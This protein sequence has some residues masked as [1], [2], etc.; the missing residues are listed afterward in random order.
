MGSFQKRQSGSFRVRQGRGQR[1]VVGPGASGGNAEAVA[2]RGDAQ[3]AAAAAASSATAAQNAAN[4]VGAPADSAVTA[5]FGGASSARAATDARYSRKDAANTYSAQQ[6]V[7][8]LRL[9]TDPEAIIV[10]ETAGTHGRRLLVTVVDPNSDRAAQLELRPGTAVSQ[11]TGASAAQQ[12]QILLF[13]RVG[14]DYERLLIDGYGKSFRV[15]TSKRGAGTQRPI[16]FGVEDNGVSLSVAA[17]VRPDASFRVHSKLTLGDTGDAS[18]TRAAADVIQ[19]PGDLLA[20]KSLRAASG[21]AQEVRMGNI[22]GLAAAGVAFGTPTAGVQDAYIMRPSAG[23]LRT[24]ADW[25][26]DGALDHD[27]PTAGFYG[28]TPVAKQTGVAVT[29]A[30]V[31][32]ALVNLGLIGA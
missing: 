14:T 25:E 3:T 5:L 16:E 27:G 28:A 2:A 11:D 8:S 32:A 10:T 9:T 1:V 15:T 29:T 31:H 22:N 26:M 17:S 24:N 30:A 21:S 12:S 20:V 19:T 4:L 13:G 23:R 18:F 6:T 7:P